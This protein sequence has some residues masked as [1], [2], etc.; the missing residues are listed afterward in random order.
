MSTLVPTDAD[1][2]ST[3]AEHGIP[4]DRST[5]DHAQ[6]LLAVLLAE[7]QTWKAIALELAS[8]PQE[9]EA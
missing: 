3:W 5:V 6:K 9:A 2:L 7:V 4:L 8:V 1:L